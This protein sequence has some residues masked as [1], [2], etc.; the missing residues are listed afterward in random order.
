MSLLPLFLLL[1][2]WRV[3]LHTCAASELQQQ[4]QQQQQEH[5]PL[6]YASVDVSNEAEFLAALGT[7]SVEVRPSDRA[8]RVAVVFCLVLAS[9]LRCVW[10][11]EGL[12][13]CAPQPFYNR[14]GLCTLPGL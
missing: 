4:Q 7:P 12:H 1:V 6:P 5:L 11:G 14:P 3:L 9:V 10:L 2:V 13:G 8:T